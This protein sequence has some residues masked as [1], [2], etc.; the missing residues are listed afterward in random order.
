LISHHVLGGPAGGRELR[1]A[2]A[3]APALLLSGVGALLAVLIS[4]A[5]R[6]VDPARVPLGRCAAAPVHAAAMRVEVS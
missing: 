4:R 2:H 5:S 1:L 6:I 3:G